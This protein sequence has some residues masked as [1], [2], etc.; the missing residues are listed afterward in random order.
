MENGDWECDHVTTRLYGPVSDCMYV[1]KR[2]LRRMSA[3]GSLIYSQNLTT[4]SLGLD[5]AL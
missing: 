3:Y 1:V 2:V 5:A 4:V